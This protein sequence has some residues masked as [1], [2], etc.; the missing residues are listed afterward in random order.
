MNAGAGAPPALPQ[1]AVQKADGPSQTAGLLV[2]R[3]PRE[4]A[5]L[6]FSAT[7]KDNLNLGHTSRMRLR[8]RRGWHTQPL[9]ASHGR[10]VLPWLVREKSS[11]NKK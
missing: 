11:E 5:A 1:V 3:F 6:K 10:S 8:D 9:P 7:G 2:P 4:G